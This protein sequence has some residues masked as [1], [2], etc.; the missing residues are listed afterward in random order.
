MKRF[1][2]VLK[3]CFFMLALGWSIGAWAQPQDINGKLSEKLD[4]LVE[5]LS[6]TPE[7]SDRFAEAMPRLMVEKRA[8]RKEFGDAKRALKK[9]HRAEMGEI[10]NDD[11]MLMLDGMMKRRQMKYRK[12]A[13]G[14]KD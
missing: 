7:Q 12:K 6:L 3:S 8:L 5:R 1:D 10:L 4:M 14:K 13:R 2:P 9:R 11:Q